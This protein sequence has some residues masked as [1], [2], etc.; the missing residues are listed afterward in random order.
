MNLPQEHKKKY[1]IGS[2]SYYKCDCT[3]MWNEEDFI[4]TDRNGK[5]TPWQNFMV[6]DC[7]DGWSYYSMIWNKIHEIT[8]VKLLVFWRHTEWKSIKDVNE[9]ADKYS[10]LAAK[11]HHFPK[12]PA[13]IFLYDEP[14][15]DKIFGNIDKGQIGLEMLAKTLKSRFNDA[16]QYCNF[17]YKAISREEVCKVIGRSGID[18][19]SS[20]EYYDILV[21]D[22]QDMYRNILYPCLQ[23][24]QKILLLPFAAYAEISDPGTPIDPVTADMCCL[25]DSPSSA[26][27]YSNWLKSDPRIYGFTIYRLKNLWWSGNGD[28]LSNVAGTG[29]GL[30]DRDACGNYILPKTVQFY[31]ELGVGF[32][33]N[34]D[35][36]N[37]E[38]TIKNGGDMTVALS[39]KQD[40]L[41]KI[42]KKFLNWFENILTKL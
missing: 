36:D 32:I 35:K 15:D 21:E 17:T 39:T 34:N 28:I 23:P 38:K 22:Y 9:F 8:G 40:L 37:N 30:V 10:E 13:G 3:C 25:S 14:N 18:Y 27:N 11:N 16:V 41:F 20:D 29:I 2:W 5:K 19:V 4:Y 42:V 6:V 26:M 33:T 31:Q 24:H 7:M 1:M 12:N